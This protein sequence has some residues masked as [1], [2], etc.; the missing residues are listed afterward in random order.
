MRQIDSPAGAIDEN[1]DAAHGR[2][3]LLDER[4]ALAYRTAGREDIIH[5]GN[6]LAGLNVGHA[7]QGIAYHPL[8]FRHRLPERQGI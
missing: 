2:T 3:D 5:D 4:N 6:A 7:S 8:P 1:A